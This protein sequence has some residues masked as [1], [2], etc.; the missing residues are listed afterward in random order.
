M[1]LRE[2]ALLVS[3]VKINIFLK[4][5]LTRVVSKETVRMKEKFLI[6][7]ILAFVVIVQPSVH[8]FFSALFFSILSTC[9]NKCIGYREYIRNPIRNIPKTNIGN[10]ICI[11][12]TTIFFYQYSQKIHIRFSHLIQYLLTID[13]TYVF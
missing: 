2:T 8:T 5:I 3:K 12:V 11:F 6:T 4:K 10:A 9:I 13:S 7:L 1:Q